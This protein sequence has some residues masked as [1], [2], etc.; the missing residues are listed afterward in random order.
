MVED[1]APEKVPETDNTTEQEN[2]KLAGKFNNIQELEKG[3]QNLERM[4]GQTAQQ[5]GDISAQ[6]QALMQKMAALEQMQQ[7]PTVDY[8]GMRAKIGKQM[9]D[10]E[11]TYAQGLQQVRAID[12]QEQQERLQQVQQETLAATQQQFQQ[13]LAARDE[14][15]IVDDFIRENPEF[16]ELQQTGVLEEIKANDRFI[17]D[18]YQAYLAYK[19]QRAFDEGKDAAVKEVAGSEP[20]ANIAS[21]PGSAMKNETPAGAGKP[22]RAEMLQSGLEAWKS[23][24]G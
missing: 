11:I 3:Y 10:G 1:K 2:A 24:G 14:Q 12:A 17:N 8:D 9:D 7:K 16:P 15:R 5:M 23:A 6:N 20:A 4:H 21:S 13:E 22:T 18:D 19:A